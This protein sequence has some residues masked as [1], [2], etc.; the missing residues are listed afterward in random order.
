MRSGQEWV[1]VD[2]ETDGLYEPIRIV[3]IA[4]QRMRGWDPVG[5]PFRVLLDH[6]VPISRQVFNIHGYSAEYLARHGSD[7]VEA[8]ESFRKYAGELPIISHNLAF[9]WNRCLD[10]EW[11]RLSIPQIGTRGFCALKVARRLIPEAPDHKLETLKGLFRLNPVQGH[12][13]LNDIATL[14]ELFQGEY[15]RRLELLGVTKYEQIAAMADEAPAKL[16]KRITEL[17]GIQD[18]VEAM[19]STK[20]EQRHDAAPVSA[21]ESIKVSTTEHNLKERTAVVAIEELFGKALH[22]ATAEENGAPILIPNVEGDRAKTFESPQ[23]TVECSATE[24]LCLPD[25]SWHWLSH[26]NKPSG[27]LPSH[28]IKDYV[29]KGSAPYYVWTAGM[30][31][32]ELS[33]MCLR[34]EAAYSAAQSIPV[35]TIAGP[36]TKSAIEIA[37]AC[38]RIASTGKVSDQE[39][40]FLGDWLSDSGLSQTWPGIE[41]AAL[42]DRILEDGVVSLEEREELARYIQNVFR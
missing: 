24:R 36:S 17:L 3:E 16:K 30:K 37:K 2:T 4:A 29:K 19:L 6:G 21:P 12:R 20:H 41:L 23:S 13:A 39:V 7:P 1:I 40:R 38:R 33:N 15:R 22:A 35:P 11:Q 8:H 25:D 14:V 32:W 18:S 34:Y 31:E 42:I 9:D 10:L 28:Y 27:P 26:N 5:A